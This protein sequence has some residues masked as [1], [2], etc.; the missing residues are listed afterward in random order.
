VKKKKEK[1]IESK[2]KELVEEVTEEIILADKKYLLLEVNLTNPVTDE[3]IEVPT[4]RIDIS[5]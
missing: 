2:L 1:R 4:V 5:S 3:D